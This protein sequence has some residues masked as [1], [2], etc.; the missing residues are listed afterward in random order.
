MAPETEVQVPADAVDD[1]PL[2]LK[3]L[4][5][6]YDYLVYKINDH[7]TTLSEQTFLLVKA[8]QQLTDE[9]FNDKL[10]LEAE[11]AQIDELISHCKEIELTFMKLDQLRM[12]VDD[13]HGRLNRLEREMP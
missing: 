9:Y 2:Q 5:V 11:F 12:F 6:N 4:A 8:K 10:R 7:I 3:Q 1:D 13:F